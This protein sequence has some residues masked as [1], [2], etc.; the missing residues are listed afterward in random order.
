MHCG[1]YCR[2]SGWFH[3]TAGVRQGGVISPDLYCIYVDG[4][5][6]ILQSLG[7]GCYIKN[8]F[9]AA[10]F[11]ADDMAVLSP[12]IKGLQRLLDVC[13]EYC[14]DWDKAEFHED[15][16]HILR[17]R[18][19]PKLPIGNERKL[20]SMGNQ[21]RLSWCHAEEHRKVQ[22][23]HEG[24]SEKVLCISKFHYSSRKSLRRHGNTTS[25]GSA[26]RTVSLF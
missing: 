9:A 20:Y 21:L 24:N 26:R 17:Q 23:L 14:K 18:S 8:V 1:L 16:E 4:L 2:V 11:Y 12:S 22:L 5:I 6:S 15:K 13:A 7:I 19:N 3:L 25:S 10:I